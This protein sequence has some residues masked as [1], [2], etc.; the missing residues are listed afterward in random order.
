MISP[1]LIS[2][3]AV[4]T[5][6]VLNAKELNVDTTNLVFVSHEICTVA[7]TSFVM[8]WVSKRKDCRYLFFGR[9][10]CL[11]LQG[12][13]RWFYHFC[14]VQYLEHLNEPLRAVEQWVGE[15]H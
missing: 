7:L 9:T 2:D 5:T 4:L 14:A 6:D 15:M 10:L 3:S 8:C 11:F 13:S 1:N 12:R